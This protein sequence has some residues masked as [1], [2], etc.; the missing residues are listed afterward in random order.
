MSTT[1]T[2][3]EHHNQLPGEQQDLLY[4]AL[5]W[6]RSAAREFHAT[7]FGV[8]ATQEFELA[9]AEAYAEGLREDPLGMIGMS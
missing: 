2:S 4:Y 7:E 3:N 9:L 6:A 1:T 5:D 8:P